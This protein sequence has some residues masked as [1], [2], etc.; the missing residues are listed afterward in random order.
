MLVDGVPGTAGA[1]TLLGR[2]SLDQDPDLDPDVMVDIL[3]DP[4]EDLAVRVVASVV[5]VVR[6]LESA[7]VEAVQS[8]S[9][10]R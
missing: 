7:L 2:P 5:M 9:E 3:E 10:A 1:D 4:F 8:D 6:D